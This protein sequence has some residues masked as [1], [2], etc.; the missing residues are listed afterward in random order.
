MV[1][2][3]PDMELPR[4]V[5]ASPEISATSYHNLSNKTAPSLISHY[6]AAF[7]TAY[8][9]SSINNNNN[10]PPPLSSPSYMRSTSDIGRYNSAT[11]TN[12][13]LEPPPFHISTSPDSTTNSVTDPTYS[14]TAGSTF[15]TSVPSY[16]GN[17]TCIAP[18]ATTMSFYNAASSILSN[19]HLATDY[20]QFGYAS[21][22]NYFYSS[23]YPSIGSGYNSY[24]GMTNS[25]AM[26]GNFSSLL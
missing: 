7:S 3:T 9:N 14:T 22:S 19:Q 13:T 24:P 11:P 4:G 12:D 20:S 16:L 1:W 25:G 26:T 15:D 10:T 21:P 8:R 2:S 23:G 18:P 17:T 5:S 6:E